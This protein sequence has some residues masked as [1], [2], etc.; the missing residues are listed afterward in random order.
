MHPFTTDSLEVRPTDT[1]IWACHTTKKRCLLK[2][3]LSSNTEGLHYIVTS[4]LAFNAEIVQQIV[5]DFKESV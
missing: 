5:K 2:P 4:A 3:V 1:T